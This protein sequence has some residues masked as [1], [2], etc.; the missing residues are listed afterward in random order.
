[1]SDQPK[2]AW[3]VVGIVIPVVGILVSIR[4]ATGSNS[5]GTSQ[6]T[7]T[8]TG[9]PAPAAST[10]SA[11]GNAAPSSAAAKPTGG[12]AKV[13]AGPTRITLKPDAY[14][15]DFD[16]P[17]PTPQPAKGD[18]TDAFV[19]FNLPDLT[20]GPPRSANVVAL[21][22]PEG[23]EPTRDQCS[24]FIAK[25]GTYTSGTLAQGTRICFQTDEGH[26]AYLKITTVPT[27]TAVTFEAT[28]WE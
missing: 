15:I 21:A 2:W 28:V 18:G 22:P 25:N 27:R 9:A 5:D 23:T 14:Y 17:S 10:G 1:M 19:G 8:G 11:G 7:D 4:L 20:L 24:T 13:L 16:S 3:W 26:I 6:S 12:P